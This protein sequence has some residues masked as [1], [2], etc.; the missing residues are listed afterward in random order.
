MNRFLAAWP[1]AK[2]SLRRGKVKWLLMAALL[3][4][5]IAAYLSYGTFMAGANAGARLAVDPPLLPADL[6]YR[7]NRPLPAA[8]IADWRRSS[9]VTAFAEARTTDYHTAYGTLRVFAL[10]AESPLWQLAGVGTAGGR[11][12]VAMP[13]VG[14]ILLPS[15]LFA[16][17]EVVGTDL[18]LI[19]PQAPAGKSIVLVTGL[20]TAADAVLGQAALVRALDH[21][22]LPNTM[23][24]WT[25]GQGATNSLAASLQVAYLGP[26]RPV[27]YRPTDPTVLH[28]GSAAAM[29]SGILTQTYMPGFGIMTMVF[30]FAAIGL[31]TTSSLAFLDRKRELAILKTIGLESQGVTDMFLIEQGVIAGVGI[32]A[33]ILLG[34]L[35]VP[36]V[37]A[38]LPVAQGI[39]LASVLKAIIAGL[40]VQA[41]GVV[42][43]A[44]TARVATVNQ[45]L[46]NMPI[47]LHT[48]RIYQSEV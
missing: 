5:A 26:N 30:V 9:G 38:V 42:L 43:P 15:G 7:G 11:V 19:P 17:Q 8:Q 23:F 47:P 34:C 4:L 6:I 32:I 14:E 20:H 33:G 37:T 44:L 22:P 46:Y 10:P 16:G 27:L 12:P 3:G 24:F 31:F 29:A 41:A 2:G 35:V 28:Q 40:V 25:T 21:G 48:R 45:L 18:M 39:T 36:R 1:L 13:Q